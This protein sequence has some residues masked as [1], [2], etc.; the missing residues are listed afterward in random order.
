[1]DIE[2]SPLRGNAKFIEACK[3][4]AGSIE[5]AK[6]LLLGSRRVVMLM[7]A[8]NK[9]RRGRDSPVMRVGNPSYAAV[10]LFEV[11]V[12]LFRWLR[13]HMRNTGEIIRFIFIIA[14]RR[15]QIYNSALVHPVNTNRWTHPA[16]LPF[17]PCLCRCN[18][19]LVPRGVAL[20]EDADLL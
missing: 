19:D 3:S 4:K 6:N 5:A 12:P 8:V 10:S 17:N 18:T 14:N 9:L 13:G 15:A 20:Q 2:E 7:F 11:T 1:M 16:P